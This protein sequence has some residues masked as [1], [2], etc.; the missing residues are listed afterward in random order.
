MNDC[1]DV[2]F[3]HRGYSWYLPFILNQAKSVDPD[4]NIVLLG[5]CAKSESIEPKFF[6]EL[7]DSHYISRFVDK[8]IHMS[9]NSSEFELFCWLRWFYLLDY[10]Q[11]N[12]IASAFHLDSDVLLFSSLGDI[13]SYYGDVINDC[14]YMIPDQSFDALEWSA[15][16]HISYWTAERLAEF[17]EFAIESFSDRRYLSLYAEKWHWHQQHQLAGGICD[18]TT[19]Y[20][21]WLERGSSIGNLSRQHDR[22]IFD[23]NMNSANNYLPDEFELDRGLK[24]IDFVNGKPMFTASKDSQLVR[25]HGCHFQGA[26]KQ[27]IPTY[28]RGKNFP[29][30]TATALSRTAIKLLKTLR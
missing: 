2:V 19:F 12:S 1:A 21:F 14:G 18:M 4:A 15:S 30:K 7:R 25:V 23:N 16:A 3:V 22:H 20:L 26:A 17:C 11:R 24:K 6:R 9:T 29:G 5:D 13:K 27:Y 8:Y 28:Y 10:M